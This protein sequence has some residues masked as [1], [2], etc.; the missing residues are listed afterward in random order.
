MSLIEIVCA[1]RG[2]LHCDALP[3]RTQPH[4]PAAL[5]SAAMVQDGIDRLKDGP[6]SAPQRHR[7]HRHRSG[8]AHPRSSAPRSP[9]PRS[10]APRSTA[11]RSTDTTLTALRWPRTHRHPRS[12]TALRHRAHARHWA[13]RHRASLQARAWA[14]R[15][16]RCRAWAL[17]GAACHPRCRE[18]GRSNTHAHY[19]R[20]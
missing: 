8:T 15:A 11:P 14:C 16:G 12:G 6:A 17:L 10:T 1:A 18:Q 4:A 20:V 19:T 7:A 9:A 13:R 3:A 5:L 2:R